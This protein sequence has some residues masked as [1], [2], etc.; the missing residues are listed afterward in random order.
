MFKNKTATYLRRAG[1]TYMKNGWTL[2]KTLASLSTFRLGFCFGWQMLLN[3]VVIL[4]DVYGS[5]KLP[6]QQDKFLKYNFLVTSSQ[7]QNT[8]LSHGLMLPTCA[9]H[10]LG[11]PP[12]IIS[13]VAGN[14]CIPT[15]R[16]TAHSQTQR[17][18]L[19]DSSNTCTN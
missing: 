2:G 5:T 19:S 10:E 15:C 9:H 17:A 6:L 12:S 16:V 18:F 8:L 4:G 14:N 13:S 1:Y 3:L 11:P 7:T